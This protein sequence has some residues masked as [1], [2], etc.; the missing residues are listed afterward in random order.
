MDQFERT[1]AGDDAGIDL[2]RA[3]LAIAAD[4]YPGLDPAPTLA[5]IDAL[6]AAARERIGDAADRDATLAAVDHQLFTV[7]G[8]TGNATDYYDPR[9]S[10]LNDVVGRRTGIPI[11]LSILYL[12]VAERLGLRLEPVSFPGHFLLRTVGDG[13]PV[14]VDAFHRGARVGH[15]T[16]VE[17]LVPILGDRTAAGAYLP[18]ALAPAPRREVVARM[19]RNL[20]AIHLQAGDWPRALQVLG[21]MLALAPDDPTEL[22][23]RGHV[24]TRLQA[25]HA[26]RDDYRRY[27]E[28]APDA[29]DAA[30]IRARV[31]A[32]A[33]LAGRLN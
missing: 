2:A 1:I 14:I 8:Y 6:A 26:A 3:A 12:E 33:P 9:N 16:L 22:R 19:L 4:E 17:R 30:D 15:E 28:L 27:L 11:T 23:D 21:R 5:A 31:E 25:W 20:K 32:L 29:A 10:Y 13:A 7:A 24:L 18:R